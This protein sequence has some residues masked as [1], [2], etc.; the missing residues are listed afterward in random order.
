MAE[1]KNKV[2]LLVSGAIYSGWQSVSISSDIM[3]IAR[4]FSVNATR[5]A[6]DASRISS[7]EPGSD[8]VVKI[9]DDVVLTGFITKVNTTYSAQ[10]ISIT[11]EG[12][13]KTKNLEDCTIPKGTPKSYLNLTYAQILQE[14]CQP[15]GIKVVDE[16]GAKNKVDFNISLTDKIKDALLKMIRANSLHLTDDAFGNL[17][18]SK[19]GKAGSADD[20]LEFGV[21]VLS[22]SRAQDVTARFRK[23]QV[24]GQPT[25]PLS[26]SSATEQSQIFVAEDEAF[27]VR[28]RVTTSQLTGNATA[29][30]MRA[31]AMLLRDYAK[32][33]SDVFTYSIAGWRQSSGKLWTPNLFVTVKDSFFG[34][35]KQY[36]TSTVTYKMSD[37]GM[38]TDISLKYKDAFLVT[39]SA[40]KS[41]IKD[42]KTNWDGVAEGSGKT[43]ESAWA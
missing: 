10:G 6:T 8:V 15:F 7:F 28:A 33:Q 5:K 40:D 31:R 13:S 34:I 9:G 14:I 43:K 16:V 20:A 37:S 23:Y 11:I 3:S 1:N 18:L 4:T 39:D 17:V 27:P 38:V 41:T 29:E 22:G 19:V 25:N 26:E 30:K 12:A 35:K 36:I 21:N 2:S 42:T 24:I 32:A